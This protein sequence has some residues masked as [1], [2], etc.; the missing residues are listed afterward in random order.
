LVEALE[1]T[2]ADIAL[3]VPSVVAELS[4]NPTL[5]DYCAKHLELI[6]YIGGDLPQQV[7]DIVA[8]KIPLRCQWGASEVG[9]PPQLISQELNPRT[10]WKY[11]RFHPCAG[12]VFDQVAENLYELV[13]RRDQTL[14]STQPTF[15]I[16]GKQELKEY[17]TRDLFA[18][19]PTIPDE[20]AWQ[21]RADDIVVFLNGEKTN[22]ITMEQQVVASNPD[23]LSGA[24]VI[25]THRLQAALL[26][27]PVAPVQAE[28]EQRA[29][30]ERLW[31]SIEEANRAAPAHARVE[32]SLVFVTTPDRPLVRAGK[33]TLQRGVSIA[34]YEAEINALYENAEKAILGSEEDDGDDKDVT[35]NIHEILG[36]VDLTTQRIRDVVLKITDWP[37]LDDSGS[38]FELGMDSLQALRL[39]RALRR[40]LHRPDLGLSTV[41]QN[42]TASDLAKAL[43]TAEHA[44]SVANDGDMMESLL[45]TYRQRIHDIAIPEK[46]PPSGLQKTP[47][48][49]ILTGSTGTLGSLILRDLVGRELVGHVFCLNRAPDGGR[50]VQAEKWVAGDHATTFETLEARVT[51]LQANLARPDLGVDQETYEMLRSRVGLVIHNAWPV[52]F[53]LTLSAFQPQL[54]GIVNLFS[55]AA[56]TSQRARVLFISSVGAVAGKSAAGFNPIP[57]SII[58]SLDAAHSN[59]YSQSK[60]LSELLC[61]TVSQHLGIPVSIARVGQVAGPIGVKASIWNRSEWFPSLVASSLHLGCLPENLGPRFSEVDWIPSN[62]VAEAIVDLATANPPSLASI[63]NS[64]DSAYVFNL[65]NPNTTT[66]GALIPAIQNVSR[67]K[68]GKDL[69]IVTSQ[70]WLERLEKSGE[71]NVKDLAA[72]VTSNPAIKLLE[73]Y[74]HGL[75]ANGPTVK[76]MSVENA[77]KASDS[78]QN[79]SAVQPEW[80][81]EWVENWLL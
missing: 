49:I 67:R 10:D 34:Q 51:F 40:S 45:T 43:S 54:A 28:A 39:T 7:G 29:L 4:Q 16:S 46:T 26:L 64:E 81:R 78:L 23:L 5:L 60:L 69:D 52:N 63:R 50:S 75:W 59:G 74:R 22:P 8:A 62:L 65:R 70:T 14:V 1:H 32:K 11:V 53:N 21:A 42:P 25:G 77:L 47:V 30:V 72:S 56:A 38:F 79:M 20:W 35:F 44:S 24:L 3:L 48:D 73:F 2:P 18:P 9:M 13:I 61:D 80:V 27:E 6:V 37:V 55:F 19:H 41:Y 68:L 71:R 76:P 12:M 33:G 31:P 66:W 58:R 57:E 36:D 15:T 17:R